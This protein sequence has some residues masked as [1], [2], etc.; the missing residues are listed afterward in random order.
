MVH[1]YSNTLHAPH[2]QHCCHWVANGRLVEG[3]PFARMMHL[4]WRI[5][6][7]PGGEANFLWAVVRIFSQ[8]VE[9]GTAQIKMML[10]DAWM[11]VVGSLL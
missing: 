8:F 10:L 1:A 5:R 6:K 3:I 9:V 2:L 11:L 4:L 7:E